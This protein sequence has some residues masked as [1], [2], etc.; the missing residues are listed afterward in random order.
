MTSISLIAALGNPGAQYQR[1]RHNIAWQMIEYLSFSSQLDWHS[2]FNGEY[3]TY[4]FGEEIVFFLKPMT[5]MN[6][7]GNSISALMKFYKLTPEEVLVVHDEL[8]LDFGTISFKRGGGLGGHN[9]LRSAVASLGTPDFNRFRLGISRPAHRD[10]TSYVLG[11]F[12]KDEQIVLP[13][14]LEEAARLLEICL[15]DGVE[16]METLYKKKKIIIG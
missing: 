13:T 2:K 6:L 7:S 4:R 3:A 11:P 14:Y 5:Y 8:E 9:G 15:T 10:I 1:T 12:S 16:S